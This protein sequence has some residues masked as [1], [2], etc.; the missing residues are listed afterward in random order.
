MLDLRIVGGTVVSDGRSRPADVGVEGELITE[1]SPTGGL[2]AA[3]REIDA[4]G[5]LVI[6]G[7]VDA[8]FHCRAPSN[9]ERATFASESRAAAS[10]GV[11]TLM[12][13]PIA[14]PPCSTPEAFELRRQVGEADSLVDFALYAG[15]GIT[16]PA[17]A[18]AMAE[19][20][21]I[22]FKLFTHTPPA[23]RMVDFEGLWA[24]GPEEIYDC[25]RTVGATGLRC[26]VHAESQQFI[27]RFSVDSDR[28]GHPS[29]PPMVEAAAVG[30]VATIVRELGIPAHIVHITS[31]MA[32]E[33]VQAAQVLGV[34]LSAESCPHYLLFDESL[35]P[36]LGNFV[37]VAPPLRPPE[38]VAYLWEALIEGSLS[39]VA[40]DHAP[41]T[42][43]E[44][45]AADFATTGQGIPSLE[46]LV[47]T[48]ID[49]GL[50]GRLPLTRAVEVMTANPAKLFG[51]YPRKGTVSP[52][53]EADLVLVDP[54]ARIT[55]HSS[56]FLSRSGG[57][58]KAYDGL[59]LSGRILT[60]LSR[61]RVVYDKGRI[62][63]GP[64]G[65][66][67][68]PDGPPQNVT[69]TQASAT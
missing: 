6:P 52:G 28:F 63:E 48:M 66:L 25:L 22:G 19:C 35:I 8:H 40:S 34:D 27:E 64:G 36:R 14:D 62:A 31:R 54:E 4:S 12:E 23:H 20:G 44:K 16:D 57:S 5:L 50:S 33:E 1:V 60:T 15:A 49:A 21:A 24:S 67:V 42:P 32:T 41:F 51:I 43:E 59:D 47:P 17:R 7:A 13:M 9:P 61:G 26:A 18:E 37:K 55:A 30:L 29:R 11:T 65:K 46:M 2:G 53:S 45:A 56:R 39:V 3:R 10:A 68:S 69:E 58:G 38:D